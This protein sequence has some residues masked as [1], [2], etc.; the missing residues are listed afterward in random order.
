MK[1]Y[2]YIVQAGALLSGV[3][4][5]QIAR[6]A[7]PQLPEISVVPG[8]VLKVAID[9]SQSEAP[10][11]TFD[12]K[13]ALV[14]K[15]D[16]GWL[17][18][19][20]LPLSATPGPA[21]IAVRTAGAGEKHIDFEIGTKAYATQSL[22]VAPA[23]V[24]LS[25]KD[26]AR[27]AR[28]HERVAAAFAT[29]TATLPAT[30]RLL[31]PVPGVRSSSFGLRRIFNNEPRSPHT[32]MDIAAP[33]G[34]PVRAAADG[35]VLDTGNLFFTGNTIILDHGEGFMT[36]YAHL[37]KIGVKPGMQV[38][39]GEIIGKVGATG[40]VTGPHLHWAVLLNQ[41][42]VDPA[43]FLAPEKPGAAEA[44]SAPP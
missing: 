2:R 5:G 27:S 41:V 32:G 38:K 42:D 29:F 22:K 26:L 18:I 35:E 28:E 21:N 3:F 44:A 40:R 37:S 15:A 4:A 30:L 31:Q 39:A 17:A 34:T 1:N 8:G 7:L 9:A 25:K 33:T 14:L 19:V 11:V 12:G 43:L 36:L 20:G 24:D 6:A 23:K 10:I 13:R 16:Q